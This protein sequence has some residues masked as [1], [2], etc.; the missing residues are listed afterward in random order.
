LSANIKADFFLD[1]RK[2]GAQTRQ[3]T[4]ADV[5][6]GVEHRLRVVAPK[7]KSVEQLVEV[8]PGK[9]RVLQFD[10]LPVNEPA[11]K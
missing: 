6:A 11:P 2:V 10:L 4:L 3:V 7:R 5:Q 9:I 1:T 8:E